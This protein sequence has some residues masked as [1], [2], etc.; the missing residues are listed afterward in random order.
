MRLGPLFFWV[1]EVQSETHAL[2][3]CVPWEHHLQYG[4][5]T[6]ASLGISK[7]QFA[8]G[9]KQCFFLFGIQLA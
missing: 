1:I 9:K 5:V 2:N 6:K 4:N 8:E 7:Y 3:P